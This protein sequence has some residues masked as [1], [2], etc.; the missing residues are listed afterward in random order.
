MQTVVIFDKNPSL[1]D[2]LSA[3]LSLPS[4]I[5]C[6]GY[7]SDVDTKSVISGRQPD[8]VIFDPTHLSLTADFDIVDFCTDLR[9]AHPT[10]R[11]LCYSFEVTDKMVQAALDAGFHGCLSKYCSIQQLEIAI[12]AVLGG[13]VYFDGAFGD[14]LR[15]NDAQSND[16][17][18]SGREKEVLM[19]IAKGLAPKQIA[20][21]LSIS[22]KTVETYKARAAQ[23]LGLSDRAK[24]VEYAVGQG[25]MA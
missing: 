6:H 5:E 20:F 18:L 16:N 22:A 10:S 1:A 24:V 14:R 25:W 15:S 21:D 4:S 11:F 9:T 13:G 8:L 19:R 3:Q 12:A 7:S 2:A 23:K 17:R